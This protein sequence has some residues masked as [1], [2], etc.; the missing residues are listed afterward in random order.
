[1]TKLPTQP[2]ITKPEPTK[3]LVIPVQLALQIFDTRKFNPWRFLFELKMRYPQ[4]CARITKPEL[5][6]I[7]LDCGVKSPKTLK[8]YL[9]FLRMQGACTY[10][11]QNLHLPSLFKSFPQSHAGIRFFS[12]DHL[13]KTLFAGLSKYHIKKNNTVI[14]L[15]KSKSEEL[16][17]LKPQ[18]QQKNG[19]SLSYLSKILSYSRIRISQLK[20]NPLI[21]IR[22]R[23]KGSSIS[24][25][26]LR[27]MREYDPGEARKFKTNNKGKVMRQLTD[28]FFFAPEV[29]LTR[30]RHIA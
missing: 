18:N 12:G 3:Y 25:F 17:G 30:R 28:E 5:A 2:E 9:I 20:K 7:A 27:L 24:P 23:F 13:Q 1:M 6:Q 19:V 26:D 4:G 22:H 16:G 8:K 29:E 15:K 14:R 21:H 11:G 10:D